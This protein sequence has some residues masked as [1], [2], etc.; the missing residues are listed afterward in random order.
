M[1]VY[2]GAGLAFV[3][4]GTQDGLTAANVPFKG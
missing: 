2:C 4:P 1:P 3:H